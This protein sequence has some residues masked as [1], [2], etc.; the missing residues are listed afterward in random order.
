MCDLRFSTIIT[1]VSLGYVLS[2]SQNNPDFSQIDAWAKSQ[3]LHDTSLVDLTNQLI[4]PAS[5][6]IER[7][8]AI[9]QFVIRFLDYDRTAYVYDKRRINQNIYDILRRKRGI[10]LDYAQ[11]LCKMS[12]IAGIEC[13]VISGFT[14]DLRRPDKVSEKPDHAWNLVKI[15]SNFYLIDPTWASNTLYLPDLFQEEYKASYFLTDPLLF[16]LNHFPNLDMWQLL[17]C[18]FTFSEFKSGRKDTIN[19]D[20]CHTNYRDS[21]DAFNQLSL[22]DQKIKEQASVYAFRSNHTNQSTW[23]HALIDKA[24]NLKEKADLSY[25]RK[26][27]EQAIDDYVYAIQLFDIAAQNATLYRWQIEARG[28]CHLNYGQLLYNQKQDAD[29]IR[30]VIDQFMKA[31]SHLASLNTSSTMVTKAI[32]QIDK[33]LSIL[34]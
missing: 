24:I 27:Q 31:R 17:D 30:E 13:S 14:K 33:N 3:K 7:I 8:R 29:T 18:P 26:Q 28:F 34:K 9:Y 32:E 23:A 16:V 19:S 2:F 6:E 25:Q 22:Y 11:L 5:S 20:E 21:I 1:I 12:E 15:D 10:C 4:E